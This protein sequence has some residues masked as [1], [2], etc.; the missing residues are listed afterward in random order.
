MNNPLQFVEYGLDET[1]SLVYSALLALGTAT[2][3]EVTRS[4]GVTRTL[5]YHTLA[6]LAVL[7]L[8]DE[9]KSKNSKKLYKAK[10]PRQLLQF[11]TNKE[12]SWERKKKQLE[13]LLP[14]LVSLYKVPDKPTVRYQEGVDGLIA[15]YEEK[16][17][18]KDVVWSVLD[19]ES[20]QS[21]E[22]WDWAISYNKRR[23]AKKI[24]EHILL[25]DT[26][27]GREWIQ[28]YKGSR[29]YTVYRW[30]KPEQ[31]KKLL[32]FGGAVDVY[33]NNVMISLLDHT[34]KMGIVV[35]SAILANIM[36]ALF[37]L[38]WDGAPPVEW[39]S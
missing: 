7:N 4:A 27:K 34:Q 21:P 26:P 12:K 38:A 16:L 31:A 17:D 23:N 1:E 19:V 24:T 15:M 29:I 5:G 11:V 2:V 33:E 6:K 8:V 22:F 37:E 13:D 14:E 39:N 32:Q 10:H 28:S 20:W 18:T 36:R 30:I 25:L 35:E 3:S 9:V